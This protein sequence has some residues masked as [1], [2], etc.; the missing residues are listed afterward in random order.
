MLLDFPRFHPPLSNTHLAP[1]PCTTQYICPHT[2]EGHGAIQVT[3]SWELSLC[4]LGTARCGGIGLVLIS[5][6]AMSAVTWL[7]FILHLTAQITEN[8]LYFQNEKYSRTLINM[9]QGVPEECRVQCSQSHVAL[10]AYIW[11]ET[12]G[13]AFGY[14]YTHQHSH[15]YL[16]MC[17][18]ICTKTSVV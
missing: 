7:L 16:Y 3:C 4:P 8:T 10:I 17:V 15:E 14:F 2:R 1:F 13:D 18:C 12:S 5:T 6:E 9:Q 11:T